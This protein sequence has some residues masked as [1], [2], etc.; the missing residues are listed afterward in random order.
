M[1]K[2]IDFKF[3]VFMIPL[4]KTGRDIWFLNKDLGFIRFNLKSNTIKRYEWATLINEE[5]VNYE[6]LQKGSSSSLISQIVA[7]NHGNLLFSIVGL[8]DVYV[9]DIKSERMSPYL[10]FKP[11]ITKRAEFIGRYL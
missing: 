11:D 9:F 7:D 10:S 1:E 4:I 8:K 5:L 3:D 2:E 6:K